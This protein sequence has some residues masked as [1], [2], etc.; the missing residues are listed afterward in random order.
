MVTN[1]LKKELKQW[2]YDV[3]GVVVS[4]CFLLLVFFHYN[5]IV[6]STT[7]GST[8]SKTMNFFLRLMDKQGGKP[9]VYGFIIFFILFFGISALLRYRKDK[10]RNQGSS[11]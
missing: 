7:F 10:S 8:N 1:R 5:D 6:F 4:T 3:I 9:Y 2:Q 11:L